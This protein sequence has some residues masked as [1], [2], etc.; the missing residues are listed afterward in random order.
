M[1]TPK[2]TI[3]QVE[4]NLP[5]G[6]RAAL[7]QIRAKPGIGGRELLDRLNAREGGSVRISQP[8][9]SR[10]IAELDRLDLVRKDGVRR[11]VKYFARTPLDHLATP[12]EKRPRV[13]YSL[14]WLT[15]FDPGRDRLFTDSELERLTEA[16]C[17]PG[18]SADL[19]LHRIFERFM[20]DLCYSSSKM[21]GNTYSL[22]DTEKLI[23]EGLQATGKTL[24]E[25]TM[26]LNHKQAIG[27]LIEHIQNLEINER[28]IKNLH[29][30]LSVGLVKEGE[31]GGI[32][33][34]IV[35]VTNTSYVPLSISSQINEQF[36][37]LVD[38]AAS[39]RNPFEQSL[40]L[41]ASI[42]YL[43]PFVDVNKRTGRLAAN[44]PLL[45]HGM[46]PLSYREV[47]AERYLSG[48]LVFYE[49]QQIDALKD[50]YL[51]G[52]VRSADV[53]KVYAAEHRHQPDR[54][55]VAYR[56]GIQ[57]GVQ[58]VVRSANSRSDQSTE[59][60]IAHV[61]SRLPA[62]DQGA[63]ASKIQLLVNSVTPD[64]AVVYG[65]M[66]EE[67]DLFRKKGGKPPTP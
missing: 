35:W 18:V 32:R 5:S 42:S 66:P 10:M 7:D 13:G 3:A 1:A 49:T 11:G 67:V 16:G 27:Y 44:I 51:D 28:E 55:D 40:F 23:K 38:K 43:Q 29:A 21:E 65:L 12:W 52:Y 45:K 50:A 63:V 20:I 62:E 8:T 59:G 22:L 6:T 30:L 58:D 56:Q 19:F 14:D 37:I 53:L 4:A 31:P 34:K 9:L 26:I 17:V 24:E 54:F 33:H 15:A 39:I 48:L 60:V 47:D 41:L 61:V 2:K 64:S 46:C 25:A 57:A 36:R